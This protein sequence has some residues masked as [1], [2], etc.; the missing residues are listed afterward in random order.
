MGKKFLIHLSNIWE[1][2]E[3]MF[4][5]FDSSRVFKLW[6]YHISHGELLVRSIK[7]ADNAK[8]IDIIF[9]DVTYVELPYILKNLKIEEATNEDLLYIKGKI[10]KGVRLENIIVLSSNDKRYF[11]VAFKIKVVEN[12]LDMFELPF[13]KLY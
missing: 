10:D 12:E 7:S 5:T 9:T 13:S 11:V 8:N 2:D 1:A 3:N 6:Y 4:K